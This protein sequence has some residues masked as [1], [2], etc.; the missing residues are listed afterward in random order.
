MENTS[1]GSVVTDLMAK[2]QCARCFLDYRQI[3]RLR[4]NIFHGCLWLAA[5]AGNM[6]TRAKNSV[7]FGE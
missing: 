7:T 3:A 6:V 4:R 5:R 2:T 1:H